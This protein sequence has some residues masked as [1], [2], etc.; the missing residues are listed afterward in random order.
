MARVPQRAVAPNQE[1]EASYE[2]R[3]PTGKWMLQGGSMASVATSGQSDAAIAIDPHLHCIA[4]FSP[5]L[6]TAPLILPGTD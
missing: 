1:E 4:A 5:I 2:Q 3:P 6:F